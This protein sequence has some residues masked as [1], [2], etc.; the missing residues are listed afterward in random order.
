MKELVSIR[1]ESVEGV[2]VLLE[3]YEVVSCSLICVIFEAV[4]AL[5]PSLVRP[6]INSSD[7]LNYDK[8]EFYILNVL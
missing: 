8:I 1:Y 6:G 2:G 5:F 3:F 4:E 7:Y